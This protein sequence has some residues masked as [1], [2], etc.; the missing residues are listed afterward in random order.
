MQR[1]CILNRFVA[2]LVCVS[3]LGTYSLQASAGLVSTE[4]LQQ[5]RSPD[6]AALLAA[7]DRDTVRQQLIARG[8]DP[9]DARARIAALSD[10]QVEAV[11][12]NIDTLPAGSGVLEVLVAVVLVLVILD[13]LGVTNIFSFIHHPSKH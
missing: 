6:K 1:F 8:V 7:L 10:A 11:G 4:Q 13:I 9:D 2:L 12:Q 5:Q 3:F